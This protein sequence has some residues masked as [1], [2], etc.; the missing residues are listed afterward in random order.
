MLIENINYA[1]LMASLGLSE[2]DED[3]ED[4][5]DEEEEDDI[6]DKEEDEEDDNSEDDDLPINNSDWES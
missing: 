5:K 4:L 1:L 6:E 2:E 3:A